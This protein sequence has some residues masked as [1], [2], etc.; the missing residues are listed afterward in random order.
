[1]CRPRAVKS[2]ECTHLHGRLSNLHTPKWQ[3]DRHELIRNRRCEQT[4]IVTRTDNHQ[5]MCLFCKAWPAMWKCE[6]AVKSENADAEI[7]CNYIVTRLMN[8]LIVIAAH[9]RCAHRRQNRGAFFSSLF[10]WR[11]CFRFYSVRGV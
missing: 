10:F 9:I 8:W 7:S 3:A 6:R 4:P 2:S 1:M 11:V 5:K